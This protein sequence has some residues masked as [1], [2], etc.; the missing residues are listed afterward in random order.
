[1]ITLGIIGVVA[2]ITIPMLITKYQKQQTII[3]LKG[4]YSQLNQAIRRSTIDNEEVSGWDFDSPNWFDKYL[5]DY[6]VGTQ[7]KWKD[8]SDENAI[9]Y[10]QASGARETGLAL[11]RPGFGGSKVY[12][13]LN[14]VEFIFYIDTNSNTPNY[15]T[16]VIIDINSTYN[17][18][19]QFGK[20]T[21]MFSLW[22]DGAFLP[23]GYRSTSECKVPDGFDREFLK[24]GSCL[25]YGCNK[26]GRGMWCAA[27][28]MKDGWQMLPDYPWK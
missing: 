26:N 23:M 21:F 7:Q 3:R 17:G 1:M 9:P 5:A 2:A 10:K 14:G 4:V 20:D 6:L 24:K 12:S 18:P 16:S 25:S 15:A 22:K 8:L 27:L 11:L 28:L 13:M 19:N